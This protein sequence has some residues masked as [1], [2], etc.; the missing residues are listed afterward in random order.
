MPAS[1]LVL[2][3]ATTLIAA[4]ALRAQYAEGFDSQA[5]AN[6]TILAEPDTA[7]AFVNYSNMTIGASFF[8]IPEAPR[9]L[10]GTAATRG[11][12]IQANI[13]TSVTSAVNILAGTTPIPFSGRYRVSFDAWINV[14]NPLP[15]GS[16]EQLLWG[17]SVDGVTPIE[18]RHNLALGAAGVY[19]WLAGEN[20]YATEDSVICEGG[21][22]LG[23]RG[24]QQPGNSAYFNGAF[25][26]PVTGGITNAPANQWVRVDI[27]VDALGVRVFY[28]GVEFH[29]V[30]PATLPVA[31]FAML[32]YED[33]FASLDPRLTV[34]FSIAEPSLASAQKKRTFMCEVG[35]WGLR[36]WITRETRSSTRLRQPTK[37]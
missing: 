14:P 15:A 36:G 12:L 8:S 34:G 5:A 16:T 18:A 27:D 21:L 20:G 7:V 30:T 37:H 28:N 2:A 22:R 1:P 6:V 24:D 19:G 29:N 35:T 23:Q 3:A 11:V 10:P 17:V 13:T 32:G 9:R 31:G 33:P 25:N 26:Q 4:G